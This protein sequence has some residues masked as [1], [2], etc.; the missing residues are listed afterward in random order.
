MKNNKGFSLVELII[1]IAIMA[2]LVGIMAPQ[3][4]KYIEKSNVTA[5][6]GMLGALESAIT[7]AVTD[8]HVQGDPASIVEINK[9]I[10]GCIKLEDIDSSTML[11]DII[12]DT[13]AWSNLN[14]STYV[15]YIKSHHDSSAEI[16][17]TYYNDINN[18]VKMWITTTDESGAKQS[19]TATD[20]STDDYK[21]CVH[22]D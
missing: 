14:Q 3:L 9:M 7:Y 20:I 13:M 12:L 19:Y 11:Y 15:N 2:I 21:K 1:V 17:L 16:Y 4:I 10:N 8:I 6:Q 22:I 5:D 18:P